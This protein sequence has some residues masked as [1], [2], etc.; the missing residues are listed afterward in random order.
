MT[1]SDLPVDG[2]VDLLEE[3]SEDVETGMEEEQTKQ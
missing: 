3:G 2:G 1:V